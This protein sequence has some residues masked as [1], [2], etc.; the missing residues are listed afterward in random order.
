MNTIKIFSLGLVLSL[1]FFNSCRNDDT[2]LPENGDG[3]VAFSLSAVTRENTGGRVSATATPAAA[4]ISIKDNHGNLSE[5]IRLSITPFG[6]GYIS[7]NLSVKAG[8]Y[9]LTQ[10]VVLD[11][12]SKIIY[13]TPVAGSDMARFITNPLSIA[14]TVSRDASTNVVPEALPVYPTDAPTDFGYA[15]FEFEITGYSSTVLVKTAV[16]IRVGEIL[17]EDVDAVIRISA[18][19][20]GNALKWSKDFN[21]TGP[22]N[23]LEAKNGYHH[24][25][26]ELVSKWGAH[27]VQSDI[28]G[29]DLWEGRANGLLP[30]TY[31]LGGSV[32]VKKL[33]SYATW[34]ETN[35][36]GEG[37]VYKPE[38]RVSYVYGADGRLQSIRHEAY[39]SATSKF[40]EASIE[41]FSYEEKLKIRT[42]LNGNT[43]S[44]YQYEY[45]NRFGENKI[46]VVNYFDNNKTWVM[47]S[48]RTADST[49]H[50]KANY[51]YSTGAS[52][53]YEFDFRFKNITSDKTTTNELCDYSTY[54]YDKNIN[55]FRHLGY[56]DFNFLNWS[57]N[58][59]LTEDAHYKACGF[60]VLVPVSYAYTYNQDGYPLTQITT[61]RAGSF[62]GEG[63]PN[64]GTLPVHRKVEFYYQ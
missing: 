15:N 22:A 12:A 32:K 30:V 5:N 16:K 37:I 29:K 25:S 28:T 41:T 61:Y 27:D 64:G 58:N 44:E 60:P 55:P 35:V 52:F 40:D 4:L 14:F 3:T 39:N 43:Y 11:S 33:A 34:M 53:L 1:T 20:A 50:V 7:E 31:V 13:A 26:I 18:Y 57:I 56:L 6:Q 59:R 21:Y 63:N 42:T 49:N 19:D 23:T 36:P 47:T 46:T 45:G 62:D 8:D 51:S 48:T 54:T 9:K 17:Y 2:L 10:F 38:L 24:Y